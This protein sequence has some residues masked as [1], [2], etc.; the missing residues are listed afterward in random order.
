MIWNYDY[1]LRQIKIFGKIGTQWI[2]HIY[3]TMIKTC[4]ILKQLYVI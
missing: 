1:L 4:D 3:S 2:S